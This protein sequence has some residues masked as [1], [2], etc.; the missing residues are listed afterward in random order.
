MSAALVGHFQRH[1]QLSR[2][3][4]GNR[5]SDH[6]L[7]VVNLLLAEVLVGLDL[8][9][10]HFQRAEL[11]LVARRGSFHP[12]PIEV[13]TVGNLPDELHVVR[14]IRKS[15]E[16]KGF[17]GGQEFVTTGRDGAR[18]GF[19]QNGVDALGGQRR[20]GGGRGARGSRGIR[21]GGPLGPHGTGAR[22]QEKG[23]ERNSKS[24]MFKHGRFHGVRPPG[25]V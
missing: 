5:H 2:R 24:N 8:A 23:S 25:R 14:A 11:C 3:S 22:Q 1:R 7:A 6:E 18:L 17:V 12:R 9:L 20:G 4:A 15:G 10:G 16:A 13:V 19:A 21:Q